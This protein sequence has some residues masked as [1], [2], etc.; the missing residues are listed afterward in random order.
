LR[1]ALF[2]QDAGNLQ[3]LIPAFS[4]E[5]R[6]SPT[7]HL[8]NTIFRLYFQAFFR[9]FLTP[10]FSAYKSGRFPSTFA[11]ETPLLPKAMTAPSFCA[12]MQ[13]PNKRGVLV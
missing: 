2:T 3:H 7:F 9:I 5:R 8:Y 13:A 1:P 11:E 4:G 10:H 6:V 12:T